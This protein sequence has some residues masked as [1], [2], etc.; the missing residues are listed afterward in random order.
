M[1]DHVKL[2][3]TELD[4]SSRANLVRACNIYR[5]HANDAGND[6]A[7]SA[8]FEIGVDTNTDNTTLRIFA[9][10]SGDTGAVIRFIRRCAQ[11]FG[12]TGP[13]GLEWA[14]V[15]ATPIQNGFGGGALVLDLATGDTLAWTDTHGWL[16]RQLA[17]A[18]RAP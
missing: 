6:V 5:E 18:G 14:H 16:I 9:T 17:Q 7:F 15:S 10:R 12:L 3:A 2:F 13:W 8:G 4:L 1:A 11:E